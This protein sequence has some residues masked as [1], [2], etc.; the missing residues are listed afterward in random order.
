MSQRPQGR[1]VALQTERFLVR[2]LTTADVSDRWS[3]WSADADVM[4]PLNVPTRRMS[5]EDLARYIARF[6]ND[7]GYM[8]GVFAK[9]MSLHI[10][11]FMIETNKM[12]ATAAFN[13]VIGDKQ[14][15]GKG[16]VNEVRAALLDDF[17]ENR[18]AEKAFGTPLARNFPAVFN[19]KAQGWR[20]EGVLKGQCK[21]ISDGSRLDQYHFGMLRD[22]WR[23][24]KG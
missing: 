13:L 24:R 6:D 20:L 18:G 3:G 9:T 12:H 2:S 23:A 11:F 21:S 14:Y 19:Y 10:G 7:N 8:I 15:W 1:P 17:F 5:K 22:E 4:G 16:V